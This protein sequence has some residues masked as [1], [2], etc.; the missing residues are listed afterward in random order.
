MFLWLIVIVQSLSHVLLFATTWTA[1]CQASLSFT[2]SWS[3]LKFMS[4]E[5]VIPSNHL[6]FS[7]SFS[8]LQSFPASWSFLI[9]RLFASGAKVLELQHQSFQLIFRIGFLFR[10]DW[11]DLL[12]VRRTLKSLLQHHSSKAYFFIYFAPCIFYFSL[13]GLL[14]IIF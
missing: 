1:A 7:H 14:C 3:L 4:I 5:S 6:V 11:F 12:V 9:S 8:C 13:L 2:N 10:I